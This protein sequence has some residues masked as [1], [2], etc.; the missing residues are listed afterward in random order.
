[1]GGILDKGIGNM[2]ADETADTGLCSRQKLS[3]GFEQPGLPD[4]IDRVNMV[5]FPPLQVFVS[6]FQAGR[7]LDQPAV[8]KEYNPQ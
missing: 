1:M 8:G 3:E 6:D 4:K 5:I 7:L 2:I